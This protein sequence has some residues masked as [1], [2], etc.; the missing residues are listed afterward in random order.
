V[1]LLIVRHGETAWNRAGRIQGHRD[2]PLTERGLAQARAT[3]ARLARERVDALYSSD[4]GR[5]QQTAREV[6]A[7][8][9]LPIR[10]DA[11]LR[12]RAF[13]I[14]EGKTWE[15]I[16][17]DHPD[18]ARRIT[19]DTSHAMAGGESLAAFRERVI[20]TFRR[21]AQEAGAGRI[22]VVTHGGVLGVLFREA[23]GMPLDAPRTYTTL[24]AGVNHFRWADDRW[25]IVR[26][27]DAEHLEGEAGLDDV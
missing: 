10:T 9:A 4:L 19:T 21:I 18:D 13:G 14:L 16:A 22:A 2:S 24:N 27:G 15:E 20:G 11:G 23:T 26:W 25:S 3:A 7:R 1:H 17:R 6:A 8:T 5:A 12:E